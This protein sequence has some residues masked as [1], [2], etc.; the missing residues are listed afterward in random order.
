MKSSAAV[1]PIPG[2][3]TKDMKHHV[4]GCLEDKKTMYL[5]LVWPSEMIAWT[6]KERVWTVYWN[7]NVMWKKYVLSATQTFL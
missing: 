3:T 1:K 5:C 4:K 2:A 6:T 7:I